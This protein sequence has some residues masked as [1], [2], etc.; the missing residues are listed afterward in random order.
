MEMKEFHYEDGLRVSLFNLDHKA[1]PYHFHNEVS[2][3][4][5]CSRGVIT[6]E[7]PDSGE[8]FTV[9]PGEMFQVPCPSRH[10][11]V[12][13]ADAGTPSR[14]VL[15]QI[16]DFD[17]N[18]VPDGERLAEGLAEKSGG[19]S[20]ERSENRSDGREKPGT[21]Y[22]EDRREDIAKLADR[23]AADRP[24]ELTPEEQ[25][26]VVQALRAFVAHGVRS[27]HPRAAARS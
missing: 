19:R 24:A 15:L 21:V 12:N 7:L 22:I 6:V 8:V 9:R 20:D 26:D 18:F 10:R 3:L 23:F 1:V 13:G 11:F 14:Y 5:Y 16:G 27:G 4:M 2:D 25:A 17:I